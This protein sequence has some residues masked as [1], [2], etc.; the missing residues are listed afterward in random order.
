MKY[1][2]ARIKASNDELTYRVYVTDSLMGIY[3]AFG[4][5]VRSRYYEL[6]KRKIKVENRTPDEII[7]GIREKLK[8][9]SEV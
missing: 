6:T 1:A 5:E 7:K 2:C 9:N 3:K 8:H 4:G